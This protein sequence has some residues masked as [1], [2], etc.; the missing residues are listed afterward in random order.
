MFILL[1]NNISKIETSQQ[2]TINISIKKQK[3][4]RTNLVTLFF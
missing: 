4:P 3:I 2:D 1:K